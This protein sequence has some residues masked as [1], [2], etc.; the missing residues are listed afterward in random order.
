M[1]S[2]AT[3]LLAVIVVIML[4]PPMPVSAQDEYQ[5]RVFWRAKENISFQDM[6]YFDWLG[7]APRPCNFYYGLLPEG[8]FNPIPEDTFADLWTITTGDNGAVS[9]YDTSFQRRGLQSP[10]ATVAGSGEVVYYLMSSSGGPES[11]GYGGSIGCS[12]FDTPDCSMR[13][14]GG[15]DAC[16]AIGRGNSLGRCAYEWSEALP[17][18]NGVYHRMENGNPTGSPAWEGH[19]CA[20]EAFSAKPRV[21]LVT[22]SAMWCGPCKGQAEGAEDFYKKYKDPN[23]DGQ[24][25]FINLEVLIEDQNW[26]SGSITVADCAAWA[27]GS[28]PGHTGGWT[29]G[30]I[31]FP[32][33]PDANRRIWGQFNDSGSI[34]QNLVIGPDY[35]IDYH[36]AGWDETT[37][38]RIIEENL[39]EFLPSGLQE[40]RE[41][42]CP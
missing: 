9:I 23:E 2:C 10:V 29:T 21:I 7:T 12:Q 35:V 25:D 39:C 37:V 41:F 38:A 33:L 13:I 5:M 17:D 19:R 6:P 40:N 28:F 11:C 18:Q 27:S 34:P 31:T 32:V 4:A 14:G 24:I 22:L 42:S 8:G 15:G 16:D 30:P 3:A 36:R 26:G 1:R 20:G